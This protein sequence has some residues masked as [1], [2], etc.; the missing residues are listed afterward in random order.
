VRHR[1]DAALDDVAGLP[2][3][4]VRVGD[5][6]A[7]FVVVLCA[8]V[9][10]LEFGELL[11]LGAVEGDRLVGLE[12]QH[13]VRCAVEV[14]GA[15]LEVLHVVARALVVEFGNVEEGSHDF[16]DFFFRKHKKDTF[17]K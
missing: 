10:V 16:F 6:R 1:V 17:L 9:L 14:P 5:L 11:D 15:A 8:A 2:E 3:L 12:Q 13:R 7:E 4:G